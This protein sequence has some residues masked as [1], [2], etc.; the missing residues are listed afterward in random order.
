MA[1]VAGKFLIAMAVVVALTWRTDVVSK[2]W[3]GLAVMVLGFAVGTIPMQNFARAAA[4]RSGWIDGR[5]VAFDAFREARQ[6]DLSLND[7]LEGEMER[8]LS[9]FL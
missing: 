7:W 9:I 5:T 8:D 3:G 6:R 2:P 1:W 4:Y